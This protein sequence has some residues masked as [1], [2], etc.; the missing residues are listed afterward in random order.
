[1]TSQASPASV[2]RH[3]EVLPATDSIDNDTFYDTLENMA[4]YIY[5]LHRIRI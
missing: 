3:T 4:I 2:N 5:D 1:M